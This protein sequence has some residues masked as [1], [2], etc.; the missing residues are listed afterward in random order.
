LLNSRQYHAAVLFVN[1]ELQLYE[2]PTKP[3]SAS[4]GVAPLGG[5]EAIEHRAA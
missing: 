5:R 4:F 1:P 2:Q 3:D